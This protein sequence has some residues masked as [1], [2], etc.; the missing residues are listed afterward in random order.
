MDRMRVTLDDASKA[1]FVDYW[2]AHADIGTPHLFVLLRRKVKPA[3]TENA[4][5]Y[6][7][8]GD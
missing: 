2:R 5:F 4:G 7:A 3:S 6:R 1:G 8:L